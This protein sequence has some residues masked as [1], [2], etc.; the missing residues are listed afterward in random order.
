MVEG[1]VLAIVGELSFTSNTS[2]I[3]DTRDIA[4]RTSPAAFVL[5]ACQLKC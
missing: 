4:L 1:S 3:T 5:H 2:M